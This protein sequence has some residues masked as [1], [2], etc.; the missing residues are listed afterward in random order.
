MKVI[1]TLDG[2]PGAGP[3][4]FGRFE[5][6]EADRVWQLYSKGVLT[7]IYLR[8]D[9]IGAVIIMTVGSLDEARDSITSLPMVEA[10]LFD[11]EYLTLGPWPEMTRLLD[12]H[13]EQQPG[14]WPEQ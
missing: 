9:R 3:D 11:V 13:G 4:D 14:W 2:R 12:G 1:A 10:G 6:E 5:K 8:T 7:E